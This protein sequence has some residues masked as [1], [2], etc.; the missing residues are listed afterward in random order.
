MAIESF[1]KKKKAKPYFY[2]RKRKMA[3]KPKKKPK[4]KKPRPRPKKDEN[5]FITSAVVEYKG[6]SDDCYMLNS[7]RIF[8]D[9]YVVN[10]DD[11]DNLIKEYY[12]KAPGIVAA[13]RKSKN[14]KP[15]YDFIWAGL[16]EA[17]IKMQ[18]K[19]FEQSFLIYMTVT[20]TLFKFL[21][22]EKKVR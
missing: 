5:C 19:E 17:L 1:T 6:L 22:G 8:R 11:G 20:E 14:P 13:I 4:P 9:H 12:S 16:S 10:L 2:A 21:I 3:K 15:Y 7:F 18:K